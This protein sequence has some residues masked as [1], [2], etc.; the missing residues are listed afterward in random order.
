MQTQSARV[1]IRDWPEESREAAQ[2]VI[3]KYGEPHEQ[4][5]S[6]LTWHEVGPWK[7]VVASRVFFAHNFPAPH[8]D[9]VESF[10]DYRVPPAKYS[11]VVTVH[12][13]ANNAITETQNPTPIP[14]TIPPPT[15][16]SGRCQKVRCG[17]GVEEAEVSIVRAASRVR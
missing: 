5:P 4:T 10:V 2:L 11:R 3:D 7:R 15:F 14:A 8:I 17:L 12:Q 1:L 13:K 16:P 6:Q 9:A